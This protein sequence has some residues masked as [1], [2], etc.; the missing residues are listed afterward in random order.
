MTLENAVSEYEKDALE[1]LKQNGTI[2]IVC[3]NLGLVDIGNGFTLTVSD[4]SAIIE[5]TIDSLE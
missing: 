3:D 1:F 5:K 4:A 2:A